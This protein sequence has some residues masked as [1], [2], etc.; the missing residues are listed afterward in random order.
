M[1]TSEAYCYHLLGLPAAATLD[2]VRAAYRRI[3]RQMHPD[4]R[5]GD[6]E[7]FKE[8]TAAYNHLIGHFKVDRGG[9]RPPVGEP[10]RA[11]PKRARRAPTQGWS[12]RRPAWGSE[13]ETAEPSRPW[14]PSAAEAPGAGREDLW[15]AEA[16][17]NAARKRREA[18]RAPAGE[19]WEDEFAAAWSSWRETAERF[20]RQAPRHAGEASVEQDE[21][22]TLRPEV[23][24]PDASGERDG[25]FD[26]MRAKWRK[27]RR[28]VA[29]ERVGQDVSLRLPVDV[30]TS[31]HGGSRLIA[32]QRAAACPTCFGVRDECPVCDGAGRVRVREK[33]RVSIPPGARSGTRLR[34]EGKGTAGLDGAT[35]GDLYLLLEPDA[36][37]GFRREEADL[38][39]TVSL[40][41]ALAQSG[42]SVFVTL[43]RGKIKMNVPVGTRTGDRFR[44]RGQGLPAWG[45][46]AVG[47]LYLT[48][49]V[50]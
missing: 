37:P 14:R 30:D 19:N 12:G 1:A 47:D 15:R 49:A 38:H 44:L 33:V 46:G 31:L 17:R 11:R 43:P 25:L 42:G 35:D 24:R 16:R 29:L 39:G 2:D 8:I 36:V 5:G 10:E 27:A 34:L 18:E 4:R 26:R 6:A 9:R 7:R 3:A 13:E 45:G 40:S 22:D 32:V 41:R 21:H 28:S 20:H 50:R 23:E 48:V